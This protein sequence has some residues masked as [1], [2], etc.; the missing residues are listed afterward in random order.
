MIQSAVRSDV[1]DM[2]DGTYFLFSMILWAAHPSCCYRVESTEYV[3]DFIW[4]IPMH[5]CWKMSQLEANF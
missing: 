3:L 4:R 2:T 5:I 1:P